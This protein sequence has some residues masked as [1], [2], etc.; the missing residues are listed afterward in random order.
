MKESFI[1]R[2]AYS[3]EVQRICELLI[4]ARHPIR[5]G[6]LRLDRNILRELKKNCRCQMVKDIRETLWRKGYVAYSRNDTIFV[7][8]EECSYLG[9][10]IIYTGRELICCG[11]ALMLSI[12]CLTI[13]RTTIRMIVMSGVF[14]FSQC[15][16]LIPLTIRFYIQAL[17]GYRIVCNSIDRGEKK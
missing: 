7:P 14:L 11:A 9:G 13:H 6:V 2:K 4:T 17:N 3:D 10:W 12:L 5:Y 15:Y 16:M 1:V 8:G